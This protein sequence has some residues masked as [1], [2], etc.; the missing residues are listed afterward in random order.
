MYDPFQLR[1]EINYGTMVLNFRRTRKVKILGQV[2]WL[3][4]GVAFT[5]AGQR[6][7]A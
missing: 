6:V 2:I 7:Y 1:N 3:E 5:G 4:T